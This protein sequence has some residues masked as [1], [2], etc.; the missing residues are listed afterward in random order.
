MFNLCKA[1][2]YRMVHMK[3]FWVCIMVS[4]ALMVTI[5]GIMNWISSPEFTVVVNESI[6]D[7]HLAGMS[8][9]EQENARS[10]AS[11]DLAEVEP[12]NDKVLSSLTDTWSNTFFDGGFLGAIGS[13]FVV[14]F[15]MRDFQGGFIKN[16]PL[17]RRGRFVYFGEKLVIVALIQAIFLLV[18]AAVTAVAFWAF[19]FT[20]ETQDSF[21]GILGW[22]GLVWLVCTAYGFMLTCLT[23]LIK[24]EALSTV[25]AVMVPSSILGSIMVTVLNYFGVS[26]PIL[27]Q[28]P[29]W[30]MVSTY[31][32]LRGGAAGLTNA[33]GEGVFAA[34]PVWSHV[35]ILAAIYMVVMA[36][37]VLTVCRKQDIR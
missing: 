24:S 4:V 30:L 21:G 15:L 8:V 29:Q 36:V 14:I 35:V 34:L 16:Y 33:V 5:A 11:A 10:E 22:L 13:I 20:Y 27:N 18:C 9:E 3:S 12:L 23:L 32:N 6:S 1:D 26:F 19:G 17:D 25:V 28:V 37:L 2:V 31:G 7:E